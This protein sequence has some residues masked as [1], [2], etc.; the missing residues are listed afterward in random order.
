MVEKPL[1]NLRYVK[2]EIIIV[3]LHFKKINDENYKSFYY[4]KIRK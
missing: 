3:H 1:R 2:Y 4:R